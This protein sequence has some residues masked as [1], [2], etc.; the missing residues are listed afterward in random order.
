VDAQPGEYA[1]E[2]ARIVVDF[3]F[4]IAGNFSIKKGVQTRRIPLLAQLGHSPVLA[5]GGKRHAGLKAARKAM[6]PG[7][8]WQR[9]QFHLQHNAQGCV[10]KLD[11]RTPVAR[12]IRAIFNA[13]DAHEAQRLLNAA[14]KDWQV[15]HPQL[16]AWGETNLPEEFAVFNLPDGHRVR[17]RTTNGLERLNK[18]LKRQTR[19]ATLF[20]NTDGCQR[21]VSAFLAEPDEEWRPAKI[22][23]NMKP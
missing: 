17:M 2:C 6:V 14:I 4:G 16:A 1:R 23:L 5:Q 10:S 20:P 21:L 9:C 22:Y 11:Q 19:V 12:Q 15:S 8:P 3:G 7:V 13:G 18:E